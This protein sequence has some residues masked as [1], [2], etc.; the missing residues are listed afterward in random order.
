MG[1]RDSA[2]LAAMFIFSEM[3]E[4]VTF[5]EAQEILFASG[6]VDAY[7]VALLI[8][9]LCERGI[10]YRTDDAKDAYIGISDKGLLAVE[11]LYEKRESFISSV[12]K[13]LRVYRR[14]TT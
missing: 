8:D 11:A 2:E 6:E 4:E 1:V 9:G 14:I 12:N 7:E 5:G 10:L 3:S 13:A